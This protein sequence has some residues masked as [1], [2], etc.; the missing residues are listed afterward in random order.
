MSY[1]ISIGVK[2]A[3]TEIIYPIASPDYGS[4]PY[5]LGNLFRACT[6]WDFKQGEWSN[7]KD[8]IGKI[9]KGITELHT[10]PE[11]YRG[12]EPENR[13]RTAEDALLW[14][15]SLRDCIYQ[16]AEEVPIECLWVRW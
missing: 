7:C 4:P 10:V 12:Y 3:G 1:D 14:L 2:V 8:V 9:C 11:R 6:G 5:S 15:E 16:A 13:W